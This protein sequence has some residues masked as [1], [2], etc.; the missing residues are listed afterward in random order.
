MVDHHLKHKNFGFM[1]DNL[2]K[3]ININF[4]VKDVNFA[5]LNLSDHLQS[6]HQYH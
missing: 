1:L 5:V 2:K 6:H 3:V 4:A